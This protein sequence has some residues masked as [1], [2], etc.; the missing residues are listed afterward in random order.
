MFL[1]LFLG[2]LKLSIDAQDRVL[3]LH[4]EYGYVQV[5]P[6]RG[7]MVSS[8]P[9]LDRAWCH[10]GIFPFPTAFCHVSADTVGA[11]LGHFL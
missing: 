11:H 8:C 4:S 1:L 10:Y 6:G 7:G 3:L 9:E 5:H 2:Q